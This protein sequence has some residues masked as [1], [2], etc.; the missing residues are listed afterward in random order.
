MLIQHFCQDYQQSRK[1]PERF[2]Q[3]TRPFDSEL[4]LRRLVFF[5]S[6]CTSADVVVSEKAVRKPP[7]GSLTE[8]EH[9]QESRTERRNSRLGA[10][11][12]RE[13]GSVLCVSV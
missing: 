3:R 1:L 11:G 2:A 10:A 4:Y 7:K 9:L 12:N 8:M 6:R 5:Q 13:V